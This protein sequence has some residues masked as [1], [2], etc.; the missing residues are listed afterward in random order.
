MR[1]NLRIID[2]QTFQTSDV[3]EARRCRRAQFGG[4]ISTVQLNGISMTGLVHSVEEEREVDPV[5]W[6]VKIVPKVL[7]AYKPLRRRSI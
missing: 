5:R 6:T 3:I 2:L 7:P 1:T 4:V